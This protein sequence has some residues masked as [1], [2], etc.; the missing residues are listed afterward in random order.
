MVAGVL[1]LLKVAPLV[2]VL[3]VLVVTARALLLGVAAFGMVR[4]ASPIV[5]VMLLLL[6]LLVERGVARVARPALLLVRVTAH[7]RVVHYRP[8]SLEENYDAS[9]VVNGVLLA[10]PCGHRFLDDGAT[11]T[12]QVVPVPEGHY[13]VYNIC[14]G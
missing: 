6:R 5:V 3:A 7:L 11:R 2:L 12:L 4:A 10:L 9:D 13:Q 14:V 1:G 8:T